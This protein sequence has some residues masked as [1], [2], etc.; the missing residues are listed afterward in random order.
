[1]ASLVFGKAESYLNIGFA[2]GWRRILADHTTSIWIKTSSQL[3]SCLLSLSNGSYEVFSIDINI[4]SNPIADACGIAADRERYEGLTEVEKSSPGA[5]TL[6][7]APS[8]SLSAAVTHLSGDER[9]RGRGICSGGVEIKLCD[10]S[11]A[12]VVAFSYL[13]ILADDRWHLIQVNVCSG[14]DVMLWIDGRK[15]SVNYKKRDDLSCEFSSAEAAQRPVFPSQD[16]I[17]GRRAQGNVVKDSFCGRI[18]DISVVEGDSEGPV[19]HW[20]VM[21]NPNAGSTLWDR[22]PDPTRAVNLYQ[23][24]CQW[25]ALDIPPTSLSLNGEESRFVTV[26]SLTTEVLDGL[27]F[28]PANAYATGGIPRVATKH[29]QPVLHR[30]ALDLWMMSYSKD[31]AI[32]AVIPFTTPLI[33]VINADCT[34]SVALVDGSDSFVSQRDVCDGKWHRLIFSAD[35]VNGASFSIDGSL[36]TWQHFSLAPANLDSSMS[37]SLAQS[38]NAGEG[39]QRL[40]RKDTES[41]KSAASG[42]APEVSFC[43]N[44][45]RLTASVDEAPPIFDFHGLESSSSMIKD[46]T[47]SSYSSR[48]ASSPTRCKEKKGRIAAFLRNI[49]QLSSNVSTTSSRSLNAL[50]DQSS[51]M[52]LT[53]VIGKDFTGLIR[54]AALT[55][56]RCRFFWPLSRVFLNRTVDCIVSVLQ[57]PESDSAPLGQ[58]FDCASGD[59]SS[60]PDGFEQLLPDDL[61]L[62]ISGRNAI[63]A[64]CLWEGATPLLDMD[65]SADLGEVLIPEAAHTTGIEISLY[66]RLAK[67]EAG[68]KSY[69]HFFSVDRSVIIEFAESKLI[70]TTLATAYPE[71]VISESVAQNHIVA[72]RLTPPSMTTDLAPP[73]QRP[74]KL[75]AFVCNTNTFEDGEWHFLR[76]TIASLNAGEAVRLIIDDSTVEVTP[77][78]LDQHHPSAASGDGA[79]SAVPS[80]TAVDLTSMESGQFDIPTVA[81]VSPRSQARLNIAANKMMHLRIKRQ[82][83][84]EAK[85]DVIISPENYQV[86]RKLGVTAGG[87]TPFRGSVCNVK[88]LT[89]GKVYNWPMQDGSGTRLSRTPLLHDETLQFHP[90]SLPSSAL[91]AS[92]CPSI[93]SQY[94]NA[95]PPTWLPSKLPPRSL[96]FDGESTFVSSVNLKLEFGYENFSRFAIC[97]WMKEASRAS[98]GP[99]MGCVCSIHDSLCPDLE[100]SIAVYTHTRLD[101]RCSPK[102]LVCAPKTTTF[103][104]RDGLQRSL[105]LEV[106]CDIYDRLWHKLH[107][108]VHE[109][110]SN[111]SHIFVDDLPVNARIICS[112][113]PSNFSGQGDLTLNIG[114]YN[115]N[116]AGVEHFFCGELRNFLLCRDDKD[117]ALSWS[118]AEGTG[119]IVYDTLN[120]IV[121]SVNCPTWEHT[122]FPPTAPAFNINSAVEF[123]PIKDL[124][125]LFKDNGCQIALTIKTQASK[126]GSVFSVVSATKRVLCGLVINEGGDAGSEKKNQLHE[127]GTHTLFFHRLVRKPVVVSENHRQLETSFDPLEDSLGGR[128]NVKAVFIGDSPT[129]LLRPGGVKATVGKKTNKEFLKELLHSRETRNDAVGPGCNYVPD[130][131]MEMHHVIE[132]VKLQF[133]HKELCDGKWHVLEWLVRESDPADCTITLDGRRIPFLVHSKANVAKVQESEVEAFNSVEGS[134]NI[135]PHV[136]Q[137]RDKY[138]WVSFVLGQ[139]QPSINSF[140]G[141]IKNVVISAADGHSHLFVPFA[142]NV[143]LVSPIPRDVATSNITWELC[144]SPKSSIFLGNDRYIAVPPV[145]TLNMAAFK[146]SFQLRTPMN[147]QACILEFGHAEKAYFSVMLNQDTQQRLLPNC[148]SFLLID[149]RGNALQADCLP[150]VDIC[151]NEW[152]EISCIVT[153]ST[154]NAICFLVDGTPELAR[155]GVCGAPRTFLQ[156]EEGGTIGALLEVLQPRATLNGAIR[157]IKIESLDGEVHAAWDVVAGYGTAITDS[158][159]HGMHA[160]AVRPMWRSDI[161]EPKKQLMVP[162][163]AE[164]VFRSADVKLYVSRWSNNESDVVEKSPITGDTV[165]KVFPPNGWMSGAKGPQWICIDLGAN[166]TIFSVEVELFRS[167]PS[168]HELY[169]S[170]TNMAVSKTGNNAAPAGSAAVPVRTLVNSWRVRSTSP[171]VMQTEFELP[172]YNVRYV[173]VR[174]AESV[175]P[176]GYQNIRI[177]AIRGDWIATRKYSVMQAL[178]KTPKDVVTPPNMSMFPD[179]FTVPLLEEEVFSPFVAGPKGNRSSPREEDLDLERKTP[180]QR[181]RELKLLF[182]T[183]D[184]NRVGYI[185]IADFISLYKEADTFGTM[186]EDQIVMQLRDVGVTGDTI[187]FEQFLK[188]FSRFQRM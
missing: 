145:P 68:E 54:D 87:R 154:L 25:D 95:Q 60:D 92:R 135:P 70:I 169:F 128:E 184:V 65:T 82:I 149:G 164:N 41:E 63:W 39:H 55:V 130:V 72:R 151:N 112:E 131:P 74:R 167:T 29:A 125:S 57:I 8:R 15:I 34:P 76:L 111:E 115:N 187:N 179:M 12:Q 174:A 177:N 166:H 173:C 22:G 147:E 1:M 50:A 172:F 98:G 160:L 94:D 42:G 62:T 153:D 27:L 182:F 142:S 28:R 37:A 146:V 85:Y 78:S 97:L 117:D 105:C 106:E 121:G 88:I 137:L 44:N 83:L 19:L 7:Q 31:P 139:S 165:M 59:D 155:Y 75:V 49:G 188:I 183:Q 110:H 13:P 162:R 48:R 18:S 89:D 84:L 158:G 118:M 181:Q 127:E 24:N 102:R 47:M 46:P 134:K 14:N 38:L 180:A 138:H 178:G 10:V 66:A 100:A 101:T 30:V 107:W 109:A 168:L 11:G 35:P 79:S 186:S 123:T 71:V 4:S 126:R 144:V 93:I 80:P 32:L 6:G 120:R 81:P 91:A 163:K 132:M 64:K 33:V 103:I 150:E 9:R 2:E 23:C 52:P 61:S 73:P 152:H 67:D 16:L 43:F 114:G 45:S 96:R 124:E 122:T 157:S 133:H 51:Q 56:G 185:D 86:L 116:S 175:V 176:V 90:K 161:I 156:L 40:N 159:S 136:V 21:D 171:K 170:R 104:L 17:G 3:R 148:F 36:S 77:L 119:S 113:S 5:R 53:V 143:D 69:G 140:R 129:S 108:V 99:K 141:C 20:W 58:N 26:R